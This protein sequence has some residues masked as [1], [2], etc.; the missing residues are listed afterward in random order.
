MSSEKREEYQ[1]IN[2][3][4]LGIKFMAGLNRPYD[5]MLENIRINIQRDLP[6]IWPHV[7][8]ETVLAICGGGPSL[9]E[10]LDELREVKENGGKV[11]ALA[12]TAKYLQEHGITPNAHVLL[13]SRIGNVDFV[14][15]AECT[16]FVASQCDPAVFDALKGR[17]KVYLYHA[18]NH[19]DDH[20]I[21]SKHLEKWCPVQG[22]NTIGLRALRLFQIL[23]YHR[24]HL[25]GYDSCYLE[26]RHHAYKQPAADDMKTTTI[27]A[28]KRKFTVTAH[29]IVQAME[30]MKMVKIFGQDWE[31]VCHGDGLISHMI[32]SV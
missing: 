27:E 12:G 20:E 17:P 22:G 1:E 23:G 31:V 18:I 3:P 4:G 25:F 9:S 24:F 19:A 10:T 15:D 2:Y 21:L 26:G 8:Q 5:E 6:Q 13:D 28:N 30:F 32:R 7:E 29:H 14:T 11:V 16:Y